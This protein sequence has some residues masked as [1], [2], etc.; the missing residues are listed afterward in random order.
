MPTSAVMK[1][2]ED[3]STADEPLFSLVTSS[4][5]VVALTF[6]SSKDT[7]V[8]VFR[9]PLELILAS[10][11]LAFG[12]PLEARLGALFVAPFDD[13]KSIP[14]VCDTLDVADIGLLGGRPPRSLSSSSL[15]GGSRAT[16]IKMS[17]SVGE[18]GN[19]DA[20]S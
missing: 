10:F 14:P 7:V 1:R 12:E 8:L 19:S 4:I 2:Q 15:V 18:G 16:I 6:P 11:G 9:A 17:I 3:A 13:R 5:S 20:S